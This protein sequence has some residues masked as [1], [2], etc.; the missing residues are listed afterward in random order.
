MAEEIDSKYKRRGPIGYDWEGL[1]LEWMKSGLPKSQFLK[2]QGI[3]PRSGSSYRHT[4]DWNQK[5]ID[6]QRKLTEQRIVADRQF[7]V[8][9]ARYEAAPALVS[10]TKEDAAKAQGRSLEGVH[11]GAKPNSWQMVQKWRQKQAADDYRTTDT[12][13]SHV[14][15]LLKNSIEKVT[16]T[17]DDGV[18]KTEFVSKLTPQ[19][20]RA[21]SHTTEALQRVQRLALG[22]STENIGVEV[23]SSEAT[24]GNNEDTNEIPTFEVEINRNGKFVRSRP[25]RLK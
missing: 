12:I 9:E 3:N 6:E 14:K 19:D 25:R 22:L 5:L 18:T 20:L 16:V 11:E 24:E 13:R 8:Q 4:K 23:G 1:R 17:D 10:M 15:L 2:G 21:L 7:T